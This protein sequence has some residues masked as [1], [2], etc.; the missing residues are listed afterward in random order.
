[1]K[2][3][4][5]GKKKLKKFKLKLIKPKL[6]LKKSSFNICTEEYNDFYEECQ[7]KIYDI[8]MKK[9]NRKE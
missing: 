5:K 2:I 6:L 4:G 1:M 7:H 3:F 9:C 8:T